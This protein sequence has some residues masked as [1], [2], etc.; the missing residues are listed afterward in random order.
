MSPEE[1]AEWL[2][3]HKDKCSINHTGSSD[4]METQGAKEIFLR[5]VST[6][7]LK[8]TTFIGDGDSDCF[9]NVSEECYKNFKEDYIVIKEKCVGHV[10]KGLGTALRGDIKST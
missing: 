9:A 3:N 8:Y 10:Q 2:N 5:S 1:H 6:R 4:S 7:N